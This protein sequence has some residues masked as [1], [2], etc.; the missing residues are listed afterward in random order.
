MSGDISQH[1][2]ISKHCRVT[3]NIC[4]HFKAKLRFHSLFVCVFFLVVYLF[5]YLC[6]VSYL[7][8]LLINGEISEVD[9]LNSGNEA[10]GD[11]NEIDGK[12]R[13]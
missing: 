12:F 3:L 1:S 9:C 11:R 6:Y 7:F 4:E 5:S 2:V 8:E 10:D 13:S